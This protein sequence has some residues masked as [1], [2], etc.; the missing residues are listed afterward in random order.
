MECYDKPNKTDS[1]Q[2][3]NTNLYPSLRND[4]ILNVETEGNNYE[5]EVEDAPAPDAID[6]DVNCVSSDN[7]STVRKKT[8]PKKT[9]PKQW[10]TEFTPTIQEV[11]S[12]NIEA[13]PKPKPKPKVEVKPVE[14]PKKVQKQSTYETKRIEVKEQKSNKSELKEVLL[15]K[16]VKLEEKEEKPKKVEPLEPVH[17]SKKCSNCSKCSKCSKCLKCCD[18]KEEYFDEDNMKPFLLGKLYQFSIPTIMFILELTFHLFENNI[19][20]SS[21]RS[22]FSLTTLIY[23]VIFEPVYLYCKM[24]DDAHPVLAWLHLTIS[25]IA[26]GI[27]GSTVYSVSRAMDFGIVYMILVFTYFIQYIFVLFTKY[28]CAMIAYCINFA[29]GLILAIVFIIIGPALRSNFFYGGIFVII[30]LISAF[31]FSLKYLTKVNDDT[32]FFA[33]SREVSYLF[34]PLLMI[35][36]FIIR[37]PCCRC[38]GCC[39]DCDFH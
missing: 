24:G 14:Q 12:I 18:D 10:K 20:L 23:V 22:L 21:L 34:F 11:N 32:I 3:E 26:L 16:K 7:I 8:I 36:I 33:A 31:V 1:E 30:S 19:S 28:K 5:F 13:K 29:I 27:I 39:K 2:D 15:D 6:I 35:E 37:Y 38:C 9:N 4:S 25:G 17:L